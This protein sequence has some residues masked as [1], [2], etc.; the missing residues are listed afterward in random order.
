VGKSK[1][2]QNPGVNGKR[3][4]PR[5]NPVMRF[6]RS[7]RLCLLVS[8][9]KEGNTASDQGDDYSNGKFEHGSL[10]AEDVLQDT[11]RDGPGDEKNDC[12]DNHI[13]IH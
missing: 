11:K 4:S 6:A 10:N 12:G 8:G 3:G 13:A 1:G 9:D 5:A 2:R 7:S